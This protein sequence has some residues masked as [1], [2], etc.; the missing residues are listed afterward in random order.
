MR[1]SFFYLMMMGLLA[2]GPLHAQTPAAA[3][4]A[5]SNASI[6]IVDK[7]VAVD[8]LSFQ[9]CERGSENDALL[10]RGFVMARLDRNTIK[11]K[12]PLWVHGICRYVDNRSSNRDVLVPFG[13]REEWQTFLKFVPDI[14]NVAGCCIP[15]PLTRADIPEPTTPCLGQWQLRQIFTADSV[16]EGKV[17]EEKMHYNGN[18]N[19]QTMAGE[20]AQLPMARDDDN[21]SLMIDATREFAARWACEGEPTEKPAAPAAESGEI[22]SSKHG[23][24]L[25]VSFSINCIK[26]SWTPIIV[27]SFC[28]P[29]EG[30][31]SLPCET[32][33]HAA[34]T[35]GEVIMQEKT[36]CPTGTTS[37]TMIKDSCEKPDADKAVGQ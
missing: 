36:V 25:Y 27:Q 10:R 15:R 4:V 24:T 37:S 14:M 28:V 5:P 32:L 35:K 6:C 18:D 16:G 8:G 33:G 22:V 31:R 11:S 29:Y 30:V 2:S 23:D 12:Q 1:H 21:T 7:T 3:P 19:L 20:T 13:T 9:S 34:G 17:P 26:E